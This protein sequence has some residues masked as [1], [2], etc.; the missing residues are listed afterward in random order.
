STKRSCPSRCFAQRKSSI[1][2]CLEPE[3]SA[4]QM[5]ADGAATAAQQSIARASH[6]AVPSKR[7]PAL[8][9]QPARLAALQP[10]RLSASRALMVRA[11]RERWAIERLDWNIDA[12]SR[13]TALYR[14]TTPGGIFD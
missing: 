10:S 12:K 4:M 13:G 14:I 3:V 9:M 7:D 6:S 1:N 8:L 11:I 2:S 5:A